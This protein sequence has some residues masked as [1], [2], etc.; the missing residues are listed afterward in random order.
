M[1]D[2]VL[3]TLGQVVVYNTSTVDSIANPEM[4]PIYGILETELQI[5]VNSPPRVYTSRHLRP[6]CYRY[7]C[8]SER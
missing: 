6:M 8:W 7:C 4:Y 2:T 3:T 5:Q 1:F